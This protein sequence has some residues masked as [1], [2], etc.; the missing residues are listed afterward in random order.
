M[1]TFLTHVIAPHYRRQ[2]KE[3]LTLAQAAAHYSA[4]GTAWTHAVNDFVAGFNAV[5]A[6]DCATGATE[7][8]QG[9][10]E[11]AK[12]ES[13]SAAGQAKLVDVLAGR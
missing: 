4:L 7:S 6:H 13:P 8:T 9:Y 10:A 2:P 5:H 11:L 12:G 1:S 3:A